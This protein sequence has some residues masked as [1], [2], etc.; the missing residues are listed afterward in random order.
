MVELNVRLLTAY[1][2]WQARRYIQMM[3]LYSVQIRANYAEL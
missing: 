3:D 2:A 1:K